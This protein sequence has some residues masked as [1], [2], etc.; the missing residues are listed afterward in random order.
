MR[1][2]RNQLQDPSARKVKLK[3]AS[4]RRKLTIETPNASHFAKVLGNTGKSTARMQIA[5]K[6]NICAR[7]VVNGGNSGIRVI[8]S[9]VPSLLI[10]LT[11]S[12][13]PSPP[14]LSLPVDSS[15]LSRPRPLPDALPPTGNTFPLSL[16]GISITTPKVSTNKSR[17]SNPGAFAA[18]VT[19][20]RR[21]K[22][23]RRNSAGRLRGL[24][25]GSRVRSAEC[26]AMLD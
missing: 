1:I 21:G 26:S 11:S 20:R 4:S 10:P 3:H 24:D 19:E 12:R 7:Y 15:L 5:V 25:G 18:T 13:S 23:S 16:L 17:L 2:Q 6:S 9:V 8:P 14:L 22:A